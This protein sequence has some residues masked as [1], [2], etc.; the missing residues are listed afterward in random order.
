MLKH[1]FRG[2]LFAA[3]FMIAGLLAPINDAYAYYYENL[4]ASDEEVSVYVGEKISLMHY[5]PKGGTDTYRLG[6]GTGG[7]TF[8]AESGVVFF[9]KSG[10]LYI[11]DDVRDVSGDILETHTWSFRITNNKPEIT[12]QPESQKGY[13]QDSA[14]FSV[15][16]RQDSSTLSYQWF[17]V[18]SNS[19]ASY[20]RNDFDV[21]SWNEPTLTIHNLQ[22]WMNGVRVYCMISNNS[23]KSLVVYSVNEPISQTPQ[24]TVIKRPIA[25]TLYISGLDFGKAKVP[26]DYDF[27]LTNEANGQS[28]YGLVSVS[29]PAYTRGEEK[30]TSNSRIELGDVIQAT[31]TLN[32]V[33]KSNYSFPD[34]L[35]LVWGDYRATAELQ[36]ATKAVVTFEYEVKESNNLYLGLVQLTY[37]DIDVASSILPRLLQSDNEVVSAGILSWI[38]D[39]NTYTVTIRVSSREDY[40][41]DELTKVYINGK[42]ATHDA[43]LN[44]KVFTVQCSYPVSTDGALIIEQPVSES[45]YDGET[46]T[47]HVEAYFASTYQWY[48]R[49]Y[50]SD[51]SIALADNENYKGSNTST[52]QIK[53]DIENDLST[54]YCV[55][56][57]AKTGEVTLKIHVNPNVTPWGPTEDWQDY[58]LRVII[59]I[60]VAFVVMV[61][62]IWFLLKSIYGKWYL[63]NMKRK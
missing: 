20:S 34:T 44:S 32:L 50:G 15:E 59:Y 42:E 36:S 35:T 61:V 30:L 22:F 16:T 17:I 37:A 56:G 54:Y 26:L 23:D 6:S 39:E 7:A 18:H 41:F 60:A 55:V 63:K 45:C 3:I 48:M 31:F 46:A 12:K 25:N 43:T 13:Y 58:G 5:A 24:L 8:D 62:G 14:T 9:T 40:F 1:I 33:D 38:L 29:K 27:L 53:A 4:E 19:M 11:H 57:D 52:L 10:T 47:F 49:T 51:Y 2:A 28:A 21:D